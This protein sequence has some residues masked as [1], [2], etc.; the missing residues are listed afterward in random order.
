MKKFLVMAL[1]LMMVVLFTACGKT[2]QPA[3]NAEQPAETT[4]TPAENPVTGEN[5]PA[6]NNGKILVAFFSR[7]G[8]NYEVGVIEKGNTKIMAQMI[9]DKTGADL[10]EIT[11]VKDYPAD[12]RECTEVAKAELEAN[13]RPEI[14][15]Y[16]T[17]L[18]DYD[19]I[20]LGYPIWWSAPPM[21]IYTFLEN[22]DF[23]GKTI[24]PFCTS[25]GEYMT[26]KEN[27]IPEIAKG[28]TI[29]EGLGIKGKECQEN[30]DAV[31]EKVNAWLAG[32]GY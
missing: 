14:T 9:A 26:N 8:D 3:E 10:F 29:R 17:N 13:A 15:G 31:R 12:Y 5:P 18:Q 7:A 28:S 1:S 23:N 25:A 21:L 16:V 2:P 11:P 4:E 22:Q 27:T 20:F 19:T 24:I 30:P 6:A 32:L